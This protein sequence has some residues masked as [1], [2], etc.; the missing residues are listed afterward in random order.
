ME[1]PH[2]YLSLE[3]NLTT[4]L[5]FESQFEDAGLEG[6]FIQAL[7]V[8][9]AARACN[10]VPS[11]NSMWTPEAMRQWTEVNVACRGASMNCVV[12]AADS[13]M[14]GSIASA[15]SSN[16][17][18]TAFPTFTVDFLSDDL[19]F[20]RNI[21]GNGQSCVL[22]MGTP[23]EEVIL[24]EGKLRKQTVVTGT[25]SCDHRTVDGAVGA[26]WLQEFRKVLECPAL[27]LL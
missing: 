4:A 5:E 20:A 18:Q 7:V 10:A 22:T 27:L 8:K 19:A 13:I 15:M 12:P 11:A 21:V 2:Y 24:V 17:S 25:L 26:Q 23:R 1:V 6:N 14:V 9:S 16:H 3:L